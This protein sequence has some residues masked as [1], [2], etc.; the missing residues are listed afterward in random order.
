VVGV[1]SGDLVVVWRGLGN[2]LMGS[3]F[4][5]LYQRIR[6]G[7]WMS[8]YAVNFSH[9]SSSGPSLSSR[10][11][12]R[13]APSR[14]PSSDFATRYAP[15]HPTLKLSLDFDLGGPWGAGFG[16]FMYFEICEGGRVRKYLGMY[17]YLGLRPLRLSLRAWRVPR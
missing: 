10:S 7:E 3:W 14:R 5:I 1:G 8:L 12:V 13:P 11:S 4:P 16:P 17:C 2:G 15:P 6:L 9:S